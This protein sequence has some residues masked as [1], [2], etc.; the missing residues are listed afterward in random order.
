MD[1]ERVLSS[2][3]TKYIGRRFIYLPKTTSTQDVARRLAEEGAPEGTLVLADEQTAGRGR[4]GRRWLAP[5][6]S[7]LLFSIIFYPPLAPSQVH[8]LTMLCSLAIVSAIHQVT[9]LETGIK[10]PNDVV[11]LRPGATRYAK[12][13]GILTE[14][15]LVGEGLAY[16]IVGMGINVNFDPAVLG[17]T[18]APATSLAAEL[19]GPV[20]RR[21]LLVA[22]LAQVEERYEALKRGEQ[23]MLQEQWAAR[24]V[25]LGQEVQVTWEGGMLQGVAAG[26]DT[27]GALL[28]RDNAGT[29]HR[30]LAGDVSCS[31]ELRQ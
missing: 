13:A 21:H 18:I 6:D 20:D 31:Y 4:L 28:L 12:L 19:G 25:T 24:L 16:A 10:W 5:P 29:L 1:P 11:T 7:S 17:E 27:E 8:C 14:S 30:I 15:C 23:A 9:G 3:T 22:L 26:V 2:L